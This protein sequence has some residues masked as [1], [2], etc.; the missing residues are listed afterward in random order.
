[1]PAS[2]LPI[3]T[4]AA[5]AASDL[6]M[7]PEL[8]MPPSAITGMSAS[9]AICAHSIT[10]DN[11][12]TPAPATTRVMHTAPGPTPTLTA[13]APASINRLV[14]SAVATFP[15]IICASG[16]WLR[17]FL[18]ISISCKES[19]CAMSTTMQSAPAASTLSTRFNSF[20]FTPTAAPTASRPRASFVAFGNCSLFVKSFCVIKPTTRPSPFTSGNF[21]MRRACRIA[22]ACCDVV[23]G[24]AVTTSRRITCVTG[25]ASSFSKSRSRV[26]TM[27]T[28]RAFSSVIRMPP[29]PVSATIRL[30]SPTVCDTFK[31]IGSSTTNDSAFLTRVTWRTCS[32]ML[33]KR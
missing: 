5:P 7:S 2:R 14:P 25:L 8:R 10:A 9:R 16:K 11:C 13:S 12:G 3:I 21:S 20:S 28:R 15:P 18:T 24:G 1:M 29:L 27:P 6:A 4:V 23:P 19:P 32:S 33:I 17:I 31:T 30:T 26:V 22:I